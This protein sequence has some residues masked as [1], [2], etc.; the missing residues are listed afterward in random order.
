MRRIRPCFNALP[1]L[2]L[3]ITLQFFTIA[4]AQDAAT[5]FDPFALSSRCP[6]PCGEDFTQWANYFDIHQLDWCEQAFLLDIN[7]Y[8]PSPPPLVRACSVDA[9]QALERR[10]TFSIESN[11]NAT[12]TEFDASSQNADVQVLTWTGGSGSASI[13]DAAVALRAIVQADAQGQTSIRFAKSA[14]A[15][16]GVYGGSQFDIDAITTVLDRLSNSIGEGE[17][18]QQTVAQVCS[19]DSLNTQILGFIVVTNG[20]LAVVQSALQ[21]WHQARCVDSSDAD[22]EETWENVSL[23]MIPGFNIFV[24]PETDSSGVI[25]KRDTCEYTRAVAGDGCWALAERCRITQDQLVEYNGDDFCSTPIQVGQAVCCT[26][27]DLPD[28]TPQP[29]PDGSCSTYMIRSGDICSTIAEENSMTVDQIEDRNA[30][31]WGWA[32]CGT[33]YPGSI[34]CLSTGSPPMPGPISNAVCGPQVPGTEAPDNMDDLADLNPCPLMACC[35]VWGQCGINDDFCIESP[36]DTGAPGTAT[37][38][39]NGCVASCGTDIV[40]NDD[41]PASFMRIGYFEAWNLN[42]PCLH[43]RAYQINTNYYTHVHFAFG[44]ITEEYDVEVSGLQDAY[45]DFKALTNVRRIMSFGG[46]SFSTDHDT[47]PIFREGVTPEQRQLFADNVVSFI[48]SEG[49][50]G[51]DFDWEYPGAP[52]IPGIP[53]GDPGDGERYLEFLRLVRDALPANKEIGIAAPASFWYLRGFPIA[54]IGEV[55]DYIVYMTYDLHGQW[56]YGNEWA[57]E[58]CP[59]AACLRSH[60]NRTETRNALSMITKA[61]VPSNKIIVGLPLYGRSFQMAAAGCHGPDCSFTGP[62]SGATPGRC[63]ETS[64]YISNFEIREILATNGNAQLYA[65][66]D[67]DVLVYDD[68]QWVSWMGRPLYDSRVSWYRSLNFGG[69]VEWAIDLDADYAQGDDPGGGDTGSGV[70]IISPDIYEEEEPTVSCYPPCTF[71]FPPWILPSPTTITV[72]PVTVTYE[73]NWSTTISVSGGVITTSAASITSTVITLPPLTTTAI[74]IWEVVWDGEEGEED[75]EDEEAIIWLTSSIRFPPVTITQS[76]TSDMPLPL[77]TWTYSPGPYP[78]PNPSD[79]DPDDPNPPPPPPPPPG[80]PPSITVT[81]G[82]PGPTCR[83]GQI[84]GRP[85]SRNCDPGTSNCVG[86]CGCIGIFCPGGSCVGLGCGGGG[87]GGG[88]GDPEEPTSC[89]RS[90]TVSDCEVECT[91]LEYPATTRTRCPDP[92]CSNTRTACSVT[93]TSSRTTTTISCPTRPPTEQLPGG[94]TVPRLGDGGLGGEVVDEGNYSDVPDS[95]PEPTPTEEPEPD[96]PIPTLVPG[97]SGAPYCFRDHN[98]EG[99]WGVFTPDQADD[100]LIALCGTAEE[101]PPENTFGFA[102]R[103][104]SGLVASVTWADNQE[105]CA[106]RAAMPLEDFC[107]DALQWIGMHCDEFADDS[108]GGAYVENWDWGCVEWFIGDDNTFDGRLAGI[109]DSLESRPIWTVTRLPLATGEPRADLYGTRR[110]TGLVE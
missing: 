99:R 19:Q 7:I 15:I 102:V 76:S 60:V 4:V 94:D 73:E 70:I 66:E 29:N 55:V 77:I 67:G 109:P 10:Q 14:D 41:P 79:D 52:D 16:I 95:E 3:S 26:P 20:D 104:P 101:L 58:D 86:I 81:G 39:S 47:A 88:G 25:A 27:G 21:E 83:P 56:D 93:G 107:L 103:G 71:V 63:T 17:N 1:A 32:G 98:E 72:D 78:T 108:Y 24:G 36:A 33:L 51:V 43:M 69:V 82:I 6:P 48:E 53:P 28:F 50:D 42:R 5:S 12:R 2:A 44:N 34:I 97:E 59:G 54:E 18:V 8:N 31:T 105:G 92:E 38:G 68:V 106:P 100:V 45:D 96:L 84:C 62:E 85:C 13:S 61:G 23:A 46:W 49:L 65:D 74:D 57:F 11:T 35:N 91:V 40:N 30:N 87:G 110:A 90:T 9:D 37:P 64:G 89:R 80:F 75:E 22:I